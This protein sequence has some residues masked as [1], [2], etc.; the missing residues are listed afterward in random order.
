MATWV[1]WLLAFVDLAVAGV[2]AATGH[3]GIAMGFMGLAVA[4]VVFAL[5]A[6]PTV[7]RNA[8]GRLEPVDPP[9][10]KVLG[11][12]GTLAILGAAAYMALV[13]GQAVK[14]PEAAPQEIRPAVA[15]PWQPPTTAARRRPAEEGHW[16]YKCVAVDGHASFQ[17]QPCPAGSAQA[18]RRA[19][20]PEREPPRRALTQ[21]QGGADAAVYGQGGGVQ[22]RRT[23]GESPACLAA[24]EADRRYRA[25]PLRLVTHDGLRR[26]GDAIR[27]AC[28]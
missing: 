10:S 25:Q 22:P 15:V 21:R 17:S 3:R 23:R 28:A 16:L 13:P 6:K 4:T 20:T 19:A 9:W 8:R 7:R 1:L 2:M 26:H 5:V 12:A 14:P 24:R 18:W 27:Q 11:T